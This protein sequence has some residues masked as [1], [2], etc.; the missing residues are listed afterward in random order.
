MECIRA[1]LSVTKKEENRNMDAVKTLKCIYENVRI[2]M[3]LYACAGTHGI[4][5]IFVC[6]I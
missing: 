3:D 1:S 6:I 4:R 2:Q 5:G